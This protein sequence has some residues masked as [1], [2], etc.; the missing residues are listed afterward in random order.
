MDFTKTF[1]DFK[2]VINLMQLLN[3]L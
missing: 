3:Q 1:T 2:T